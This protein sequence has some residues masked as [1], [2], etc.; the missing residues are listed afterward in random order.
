MKEQY[1]FGIIDA[2]LRNASMNRESA[3]HFICATTYHLNFIDLSSENPHITNQAFKNKLLE[4]MQKYRIQTAVLTRVDF[5]RQHLDTKEKMVDHHKGIYQRGIGRDEHSLND[6]LEILFET[7]KLGQVTDDNV[8]TFCFPK[9]TEKEM[10]LVESKD[11]DH[12]ASYAASQDLID[13]D[14]AEMKLSDSKSKFVDVQCFRK[15]IV[16]K[17]RPINGYFK[18]SIDNRE[19]SED[20]PKSKLRRRKC[21]YCGRLIKTKP[22][23]VT[24]RYSYFLKSKS[25]FKS[26]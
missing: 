5:C 14:E 3:T 7:M 12:L 16:F 2:A 19:Q 11:E 13:V 24:N 17:N 18:R 1:D 6:D 22:R 10:K 4:G 15:T 20:E 8:I 26:E 9:L 25:P 23:K 21:Y